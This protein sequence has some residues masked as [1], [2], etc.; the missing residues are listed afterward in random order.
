MTQ[1]ASTGAIPTPCVGVCSTVYGDRVCRG[2]KRF[3]HEIIR[4]NAYSDDERAAIMARLEQLTEQIILHRFQVV[5]ADLLEQALG[6]YRVRY[7]AGRQPAHRVAELVRTSADRI[8]SLESC[9]VAALPP[10]DQLPLTRLRDHLEEELI[11]LA[12]AYLQRYFPDAA[13]SAPGQQE[14]FSE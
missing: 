5:D 7:H 14:L 8:M 9:G 12:E 10:W 3:A 4:W 2:C 1:E 6:R 13:A 11:M